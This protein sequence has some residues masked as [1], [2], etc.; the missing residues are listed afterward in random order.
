[1]ANQVEKFNIVKLLTE[2][3]YLIPI[4]QREYAWKKP[5][6]EQLIQDFWDYAKDKKD[7]NYYIGTLVT[8]LRTEKD[9]EHI[10]KYEVLDGQQRL[11]TLYILV[12]A[13]KSLEQDIKKLYVDEKLKLNLHFK[14]RDE[15]TNTLKNILGILD[16]KE[17]IKEV[18]PRIIKGFEIAKNYLETE[19]PDKSKIDKEKFTD[20]LLE[21]VTLVRTIVPPDTDLNH[22]FEIMNNRGEQL[23]KHEILKAQLLSAI[24]DK[25][26]VSRYAKVW[27]ACSQMGEYIKKEKLEEV[28]EYNSGDNII[29]IIENKDNEIKANIKGRKDISSSEADIIDFPNFLLQVLKVTESDY[30]RKKDD[31]KTE[32][33]LND[34]LLQKQFD[35]FIV[36][37]CFAILFIDNLLKYR[38]WFDKYII[39][40][41]KNEDKWVI[42]KYSKENENNEKITFQDDSI[43]MIQSMFHVSNS[44]NA[45]KRWLQEVLK[46]LKDD[47]QEKD[48]LDGLENISRDLLNDDTKEKIKKY[49]EDDKEFFKDNLKFDTFPNYLFNLLDYV[50]WKKDKPSDFSFKGGTREHF[51]PQN[52]NYSK[53]VTEDFLHQ[54]GNLALTRENSSL[55]NR[56]PQ[57]KKNKIED[58]KNN[59]IKEQSLKFQLMLSK[60]EN[61]NDEAIQNHQNEMITLLQKFLKN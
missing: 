50:I 29:S 17:E 8:H 35:K 51:Y 48:F 19:Q 41:D 21:K 6:I 7:S 54:F 12:A 24:K 55:S 11:T 52:D 60:A 27:D 14:A 45:N 3:N 58:E 15:Y 40:K 18:E 57:E 5:E 13:L 10:G 25:E 31:D 38:F 22:Y 49:S 28:E 42:K 44:G 20:Y 56:S 36:D 23:E 9:K 2:D 37:K 47:L 30:K 43:K 46:L 26:L 4:Y 39:R 16:E 53:G 34:S 1:M 33:S 61:W 59:K 32:I